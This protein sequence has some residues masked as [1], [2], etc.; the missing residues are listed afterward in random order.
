MNSFQPM[1][2]LASCLLTLFLV[3]P[4]FGARIPGPKVFVGLEVPVAQRVSIDRIDH[5][6]WDQLLQEYVD[7][8][9]LVDYAGWQKSKQDILALDEYLNHLSS[10][11]LQAKS[12]RDARLAFWINAYNA[13]TVKGILREYPTRS[14]RKHTSKGSGYNIWKDLLLKVGG[15]GVSLDEIEHK[16][17]RPM[18]E[19]R[20][21]FA[22]VCASYSCPPLLNRAYTA[23]QLDQQLTGNSR[24][25]FA[26]PENFQHDQRRR[27][28]RLSAIM[29]WFGND[30]GSTRAD[31]LKAIS[32]YLPTEEARRAALDSS[33][34]TSFLKYDWSLNEQ[35]STDRATRVSP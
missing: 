10:A 15:Q 30:F 28:F 26:N 34:R 27:R 11:N 18:G 2:K 1:S 6:T 3:G 25:F 16:V 5:S 23:D 8:R 20:I 14:I 4:L 22:I 21:H 12:S 31:Q 24:R 32:P 17:L 19:P 35:H 33:V 13:V 9:G 29:D 7:D